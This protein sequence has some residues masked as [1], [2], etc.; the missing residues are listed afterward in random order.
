MIIDM[1]HPW[2]YLLLALFFSALFSGLEIAFISANKLKVEL[3][4]S[5]GGVAANIIAKF[6]KNPSKFIATMLIGNNIALVV[7]SIL[8]ANYLEPYIKGYIGN[9]ALVLLIQTVISTIIVLFFAE[10]LPKAIM[11]INPNRTLRIA[12]LPIQLIYVVL[13]PITSFTLGLSNIILKL[14]KLDTSESNQAFSRIDLEHF[15]SDLQQNKEGDEV[16]HEIQIFKNALE[17]SN[18]KVRDCMIPRTEIVALNIDSSIKELLEHFIDTGLSKI[19]IYRDNIDNIIGYT[20]SFELFKKPKSIK[21]VLL[22][23]SIVPES[24]LA[25]EVFQLFAKQHRSIA[26]VVD[27]F[28]GTSGLVTVEDIV[29]EIFGEIKDEHDKEELVEEQIEDNKYLLSARLEIDYLN[30]KYNLD[31]PESEDYETIAGLLISFCED[32][33]NKDEIIKHDRF[34]FTVNDVSDNRIEII[35]LEIIEE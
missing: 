32:I 9:E 3:D 34:A 11:Q 7:Y 29:E 4:K 31:L 5:Q 35:T 19:L 24:M 20:H 27:E 14:F 2:F 22:P 33:P 18:V 16:D 30:D 15:L 13:Y 26:V 1:N 21:Q 10:F 8:M 17:F 25:N 28:G 23:V 12:A 6:I